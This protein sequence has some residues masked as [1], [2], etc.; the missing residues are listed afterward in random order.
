MER[1]FFVTLDVEFR[2]RHKPECLNDGESH[3]QPAADQ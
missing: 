2:P 3:G 1:P